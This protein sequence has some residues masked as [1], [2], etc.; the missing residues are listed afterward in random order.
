MKEWWRVVSRNRDIGRA[1]LMLYICLL[2]NF[3]ISVAQY[4][5]FP[6]DIKWLDDDPHSYRISL[7][8]VTRMFAR[9]YTLH[10]TNDDEIK[11]NGIIEYTVTMASPVANCILY[12][13]PHAHI[14]VTGLKSGS[15]KI[16]YTLAGYDLQSSYIT[17]TVDEVVANAC[18]SGS[19]EYR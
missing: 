19:L 6:E 4:S 3:R 7:G 13:E 16:K 14:T 11:R 2:L 17:V 12:C 8:E 1:I 18:P 10:V 5:N 9:D 15:Q